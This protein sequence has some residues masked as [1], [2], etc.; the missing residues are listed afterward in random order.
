MT[1]FGHEVLTCGGHGW[2]N[3]TTL[4]VCELYTPE[5]DTWNTFA[6]LPVATYS[7]AMITLRFGDRVQ[8]IVFGGYNGMQNVRTVY[9][10]DNTAWHER[11]HMPVPLIHH[12]A[13][14]L[15]NTT[16]IVCGGWQ[17]DHI[18]LSDCHLYN[19]TTDEWLWTA[20]MNTERYGH[21]MLVYLSWS[22][23]PNCMWHTFDC[24]PR[25]GVRWKGY[26]E[27]ADIVSRVA[28]SRRCRRMAH[29]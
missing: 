25:M 6:S 22:L 28:W 29:P 21:G 4:S 13:V 2:Y 19:A 23:R 5:T 27:K 9:T 20:P 12:R 15:D 16:A 11:A 26:M 24:R 7:L 3:G 17:N 8:P 14:Q 10:F 1:M 18:A